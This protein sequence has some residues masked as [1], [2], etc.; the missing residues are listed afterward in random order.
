M[1]DESP[2]EM[3]H[4]KFSYP[5]KYIWRLPHSSKAEEILAD[6]KACEHIKWSWNEVARADL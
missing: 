6:Q 2:T 3:F 1:Q 4:S 5:E